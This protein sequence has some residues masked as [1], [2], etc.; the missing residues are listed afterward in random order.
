MVKDEVG[1]PDFQKLDIRVGKVVSA[2]YILGSTNLIRL[3][4]QLG[5]D[6]GKRIIIAGIAKWHEPKDL[7]G[8]KFLFVANLAPKKMMQEVS[9][10]MILCADT[11]GVAK[12]I[13]ISDEL[14]EGTV[15]R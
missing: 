7:K 1:F 5:R 13:P 11:E 15:I 4:V 6:Y 2:E 10:G 8:K 9:N 12:V 3:E 14:K